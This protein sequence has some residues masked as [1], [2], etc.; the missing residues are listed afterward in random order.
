MVLDVQMCEMTGQEV[1][2]ELQRRNIKIPVI[3]MS[4]FSQTQLSQIQMDSNVVRVLNKPFRIA[5]LIDAIKT[6]ADADVAV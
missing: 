3:L 4:G 5:E 1:L 6:V 2:A